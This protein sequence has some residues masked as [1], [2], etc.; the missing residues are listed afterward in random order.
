MRA[1]ARVFT[2]LPALVR[3]GFALLGAG[4]AGDAGYHLTHGIRPHSHTPGAFDV[5]MVIHL[6]V[7]A[8]MALCMAGVVSAGIRSVRSTHP[9]RRE[10]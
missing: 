8:G 6:I 5:A 2:E 4:I 10:Q 3:A 1:L 9:R 7:V